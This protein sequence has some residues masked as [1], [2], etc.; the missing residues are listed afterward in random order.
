[1]LRF[2][3]PPPPPP[4][5]P[6]PLLLTSSSLVRQRLSA[7]ESKPIG[8][9]NGRRA[10]NCC[11]PQSRLQVVSVSGSSNKAKSRPILTQKAILPQVLPRHPDHSQS[12]SSP[13]PGNY[14]PSGKK[15]KATLFKRETGNVEMLGGGVE[16]EVK[17]VIFNLASTK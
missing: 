2:P 11:L 8:E 15:P 5:P 10:G 13:C 12:F 16:E 1:M 17:L 3:P 9:K 4:P 6:L 14:M 7:D